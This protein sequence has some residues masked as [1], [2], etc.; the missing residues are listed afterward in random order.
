MFLTE[1]FGS[2]WAPDINPADT[3]MTPH[4]K[5]VVVDARQNNDGYYVFFVVEITDENSP[6]NGQRADFN[7]KELQLLSNVNSKAVNY[8]NDAPAPG[9][10][11]DD[12]A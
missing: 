4:G 10:H 1:M 11:F 2:S 3:V 12:K 8:L 7:I 9:Q 6:H 5:G